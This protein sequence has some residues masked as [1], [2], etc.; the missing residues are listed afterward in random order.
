MRVFR[1]CI[2]ALSQCTLR[3]PILPPAHLLPT[4][5]STQEAHMT[6]KHHEDAPSFRADEQ[7]A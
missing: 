5:P 2:L 4:A 6:R 1:W 7:A 3:L